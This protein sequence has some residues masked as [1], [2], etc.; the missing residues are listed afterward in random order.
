VENWTPE[1]PFSNAPADRLHPQFLASIFGK[2]EQL[3]VS[4]GV[5]GSFKKTMRITHFLATTICY[6]MTKNLSSV[7]N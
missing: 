4:P 6:L 5:Y 7:D 3:T 1:A 2:K